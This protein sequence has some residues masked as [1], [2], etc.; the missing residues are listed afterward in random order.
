MENAGADW[1]H[2]DVM[3]SHLVPNLAFGPGIQ[4][5]LKKI[6]TIPLDTHLMMSHPST[7]IPAFIEQGSAWITLH[8]ECE[9]NLPELFAL[10]R[11][12]GAKPGITLKPGTAVD[13]L[14]PYLNEV[15]LALVMTVEP[16]FGGQSFMP[17]MLPKIKW[18]AEQRKTRGLDYHIEVDG[19]INLDTARP[20]VEAGADVLV[21]GSYLYGSKDRSN[22][23]NQMKALGA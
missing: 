21:S 23:V 1:H 18:L 13:T 17:D 10:I 14:L 7:V 16:G 3:D 6:A 15:D 12:L 19:G 11:R 4:H 9:E 20:C 22:A 8:V 5:W 2:V